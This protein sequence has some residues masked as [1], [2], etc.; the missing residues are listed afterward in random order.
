MQQIKILIYRLL[1]FMKLTCLKKCKSIFIFIKNR[2]ILIFIFLLNKLMISLINE[3]FVRHIKCKYLFYLD[4]FEYIL[5]W[6]WIQA[7]LV[8]R[9]DVRKN[10]R[11][12]S[13]FDMNR[14]NVTIFFKLGNTFKISF[15][16]VY[17]SMCSVIFCMNNALRYS[18]IPLYVI[19]LF[20]LHIIWKF[21]SSRYVD[22]L[23]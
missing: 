7:Q 17:D 12:I 20:M 19:Y 14:E 1:I 8:W 22:L 5:S 6:K 16:N 2:L 21:L 13:S 18:S 11:N 23:I 3:C 4:L 15:H 10:E 9:R